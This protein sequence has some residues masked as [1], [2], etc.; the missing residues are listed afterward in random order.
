MRLITL[1]SDKLALAVVHIA[2][3][4]ALDLIPRSR[5]PSIG[6]KDCLMSSLL[7]V[8]NMEDKLNT[9]RAF[10]SLSTGTRYEPALVP[11]GIDNCE[12]IVKIGFSMTSITTGDD[13][14][15]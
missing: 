3:E 12:A 2:S 14:S 11:G 8:R 6:V 9:Y 1:L 7:T 5:R 4:F 10:P 15:P 13:V